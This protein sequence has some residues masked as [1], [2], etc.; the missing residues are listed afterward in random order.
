VTCDPTLE[1]ATIVEGFAISAR[2]VCE[3]RTKDQRD[4]TVEKMNRTLMCH[5]MEGLTKRRTTAQRY[6]RVFTVD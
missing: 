4:K 2:H 6:M 5:E 3:A 1:G